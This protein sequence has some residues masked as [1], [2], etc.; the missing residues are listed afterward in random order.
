MINPLQFLILIGQL[1][2]LGVII[3]LLHRES[4]RVGLSPLIVLL[5]GIVVALQFRLL[6]VFPVNILGNNLNFSPGSYILLPNL[7]LGL[8]LIY[9][10]NGSI[11]ARY[12]LTGIIIISLLVALYQ[13]LPA[14][15]NALQVEGLFTQSQANV[16]PRIPLASA[17][18]ILVDMVVLI[19]VYQWLSNWRGKFPSRAASGAAIFTA[20]WCDAFLFPLLAYLGKPDLFAQLPVNLFGKS[21]SAGLLWVLAFIYLSR[22]SHNLPDSIAAVQRPVL[23][24]FS[25]Q[26]Q[27]EQR[28]RWHFN[29]LQTTNKIN[30]LI[31]RS[32]DSNTLLQQACELLTQRLEYQLAWVGLCDDEQ[33]T[34]RQIV[35]RAGEKLDL[36]DEIFQLSEKNP[37][38]P[39][40]TTTALRTNK[41][42][43]HR[44]DPRNPLNTEWYRLITNNRIAAFAAF[45]MRLSNRPLGVLEVY[46][47]QQHAFDEEEE[48]SLLQQLA[49]DLAY[50]MVSLEARQQQAFLHRSTETMRDGLL[51]TDAKGGIIYANPAIA[52]LLQYE[53]QDILGR[54]IFSFMTDE[55]VT[56]TVDHILPA[57]QEDRQ[58]VTEVKIL[59]KNLKPFFAE[60][61]IALVRNA[62]NEPINFIVNVRD[63]TR[64]RIFE[65][66]LM[67]LNRFTTELAQ[68]RDLDELFRLILLAGEELLQADASAISID[69][70][71]PEIESEIHAHN[72]TESLHSAVVDEFLQIKADQSPSEW[73]ILWTDHLV[74]EPFKQELKQHLQELGFRSLMLLAIQYQDIRLGI[75]GLYYRDPVALDESVHQ[76]GITATQTLAIALQNARLYQSEHSQRQF[77]EAIVHASESLNSS[78]DLDQVLSQILEQTYRVVPCTSVNLML[79]EDEKAIV[80]RQL[81]LTENGEIENLSGGQ[82][83]PLSTPTLTRM[84]NTGQPILITDTHD[85]P[86]WKTLER[87]SW[88]RSY[89]SAPL[90][91]RQEVIGFLNVNSREP[92]F[93]N[94]ESCR[95]LQAFASHAAAALHNARLYRDLQQYSIQLEERVDE[96]TAELSLSKERIEAILESVP[97]A[98]FVLDHEDNLLESNQAGSLLL[99][100]YQI[101]EKESLFHHAFMDQLKSGEAPNENA[102]VEVNGRIYQ[103]LSSPLPLPDQQAGLVI[104]FRDVTRFQELD[105]MKSQFVSDVSHELRTPLANLS[106]FLDLLAN[107][108]TPA[109]RERYQATLRR[110]TDRLTELIEDLL[111]ISRLESNRI[112]FFIKEVDVVQLVSELV[113]DRIQMAQ[114]RDLRLLFEC[115][116]V[117]PHALVDPR[118]LTQ[119]LSNILTNAFNYTPPGGQIQLSACHEQT[120]HKG[121][122]KISVS[123]NGFGILPEELPNIFERFFR[124]SASRKTAAPGTGL[125]LA[126]SQ[127]IIERMG[128]RIIVVSEAGK[129]STFTIW[130]QSVL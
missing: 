25:T 16:S 85:E 22:N 11:Q 124:G 95:R 34:V 119:V 111:T 100:N 46:A 26:L 76:M 42:V 40:P 48:L 32:Q 74:D 114:K 53:L 66:R 128:G 82:A 112:A 2:L 106:L 98:V 13:S 126:I 91:I 15:L 57:L 56:E 19:V 44:I 69:R 110:E 43:I 38:S 31:V 54:S 113:D 52:D 23:D 96:R 94:A 20:L 5:G 86:D 27:L 77:A 58:L 61:T 67:A 117:L 83:L 7:L 120:D 81:H 63:S 21:I 118:L 29:L 109:K 102:I 116:E 87:S 49:D 104:V 9:I 123:D 35:A 107:E 60:L 130:V 78:L 84:I 62:R 80:V 64:R 33:H 39:N 79:V 70:L 51:I 41:A 105:R 10:L 24:I 115:T 65:H 121:W 122:I 8:L 71:S 47:R 37:G 4:P 127:E 14:I 6:G 73:N 3:L 101:N 90:Q 50:A 36:V 92:N 129:G 108:Q 93:F 75:L 99:Q 55:Q 97:D 88:I 125:G 1:T 30:Q 12:A 28:A 18:T 17:I 103:A 89:A 45:P 59:D 68:I 72:I